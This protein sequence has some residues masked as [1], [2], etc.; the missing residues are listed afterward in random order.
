MMKV[1]M[2]TKFADVMRG[3][4]DEAVVEGPAAVAELRALR[5][6]FRLGRQVAEA[7]LRSKLSQAQVA[8][9]ARVDQADVS[10]IERGVANPTLGTLSA[11]AGAVGLVLDLKRRRPS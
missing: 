9:R 10:R 4:E 1:I 5:D 8:K 2:A 11:V 3:I 7:R 6:H